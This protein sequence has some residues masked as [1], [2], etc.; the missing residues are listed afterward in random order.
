[1]KEWNRYITE[2]FCGNFACRVQ[3][4]D[5]GEVFLVPVQEDDGW[6]ADKD[7]VQLCIR[8]AEKGKS[9]LF[10]IDL[11]A[12]KPLAGRALTFG[13][14]LAGADAVLDS[15]HWGPWW[16]MC[17][18]PEKT[19]DL[20]PKTQ[21]FLLKKGD[22]HISIVPLTGD[23]FRCEGDSEGLWLDSG[24]D[25]FR[26]F[27]G[28]FLTVT[29]A[30]DPFAAVDTNYRFAREYGGI[31]VPLR[32]ER[33]Y[34]AILEK[35]GWC[36]WDA[37][38]KEVTADKI[39]EKLA[40]FRDKNV[41]VHWIIIDAG[42]STFHDRLLYDFPADP[43]KF[44]EGLAGCI[45]RCKEEFGIEQVGV[46]HTFN[47]YWDG[48]EPG[49][50]A[51]EKY[52]DALMATA[53]GLLVP[54]DD[55]DR[56]IRFWD[57]WH[58]YLASCGVDFVKVDNQSSTHKYLEGTVSTTAG[59]VRAHAVLEKSIEKHFGGV[60]INCMGMDMEN[61]LARPASGVARNSDDF[62][63]QKENGFAQHIKQNLYCAL[64]HDKLYHCDFDMWWSGKAAPVQSGLL[65][66]ISGGPV[67][68]SD[69]VG[70][71]DRNGVLPVVG[72]DG[73]IHRMDH[74]AM[75]TADC[76]YV[77]CETA[78][79]VMKAWNR[80]GNAFVLAAFNISRREITETFA[81]D[82]VP[83]LTGEY[84]AY[85]YFTKTFTEVSGKT[86]ISLTLQ[87]EDVRC[88]SLYPVC[89]ENGEKYILFGDPGRYTGIGVPDK[90]KVLL[91]EIL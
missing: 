37:F 26:E 30:E 2:E 6:R 38:Y 4:A 34:P 25:G 71:T 67:Y 91:D 21:N 55:P 66:A 62:Y 50:P 65:R 89:E 63:P 17:G 61:V 23:V 49:S 42:W 56:A 35:F 11:T 18:W 85:E 77:D 12:E 51:A 84:V 87:A 54:H 19:A 29:E 80:C 31:R 22:T 53:S 3:L 47:A 46:W 43:A 41:P 72:A 33:A 90:R 7:G 16:M 15:H 9:A 68:V 5:G 79:R 86:E 73:F 83:G 32:E 1:M 81:L 20:Q 45:R 58:G 82:V 57:G 13:L 8:M 27:H 28:S 64:W 14:N 52:A 74:A 40:E 36:T 10:T 88:W 24:C 44:P 48:V 75:P 76:L 69:K 60:V 70:E 59:A 39:Y 78:G